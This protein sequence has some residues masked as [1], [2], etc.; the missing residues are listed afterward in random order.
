M[1]LKNKFFPI[2]TIAVG[3]VVFSTGAL[4][5]DEKPAAPAAPQKAAKPFKGE[6]RGFGPGKADRQGFAG[7]H[8]RPE[9]KMRGG[10]MAMIRGLNLTDAQKE[11]IRGIMQSN[12]P[13]Q[14]NID[15]VTTF[16]ESKKDGTPPT[17]EQKAQ[18]KAFREQA[19]SRAK[20]VHEQIL[21]VLTA[22]Q[23]AQLEQRHQQMNE[24]R[25]EFQQ[26]HEEFRK[27]RPAKPAAADKPKTF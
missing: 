8:S 19:Q 27:N 24:R 14:A 3:V 17:P 26:K 13:D 16:R 9:G 5:Q 1:S 20:S 21:N 4:A 22:D 23:K 12:R 15:R 7:R 11:Q 6:G 18:M 2:L 10:P 25:K